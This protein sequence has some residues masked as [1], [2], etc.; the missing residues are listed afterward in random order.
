MTG[1][2]NQEQQQMYVK[3]RW[4]T[5]KSMERYLRQKVE[6]HI[7]HFCCVVISAANRLL[8]GPSPG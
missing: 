2:E 8:L 1:E 5:E 7:C 6:R 3:S 4:E